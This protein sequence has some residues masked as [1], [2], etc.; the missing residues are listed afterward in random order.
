MKKFLINKNTHIHSF[1]NA[2]KN[3]GTIP[4]A[5]YN[6]YPIPYDKK[7]WT[8]DFIGFVI[9][10]LKQIED[11]Y[12]LTDNQK[13]FI[14]YFIRDLKNISQLSIP[15]ML[16][17]V[18]NGV[19]PRYQRAKCLYDVFNNIINN[20]NEFTD[21]T[22]DNSYLSNISD[23]LKHIAYDKKIMDNLGWGYKVTE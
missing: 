14:Q 4:I 1:K 23:V 20:K 17:T 6:V 8:Y 15:S 5:Q 10:C 12:L 9:D 21:L 16:I 11:T 13:K 19:H 2:D 3:K 22:K 7:I 18:V